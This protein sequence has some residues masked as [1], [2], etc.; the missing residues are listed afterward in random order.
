[1]SVLD[2]RFDASLFDDVGLSFLVNNLWPWVAVLAAAISFWRIRGSAG[3]S[4]SP[5]KPVP[6]APNPAL[7]AHRNPTDEIGV[8]ESPTKPHR[9]PPSHPSAADN[10]ASA[11]PEASTTNA[12][13]GKDGVTKGRFI[14]YYKDEEV[15]REN[16]DDDE[17]DRE[18][19]VCCGGSDGGVGVVRRWRRLGDRERISVMMG[20]GAEEMGWHKCQDLMVFHGSVVRLWQGL[21]FRRSYSW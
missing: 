21:K 8:C 15:Q 4:G 11:S 6:G 2:S 17:G 18:D 1:M 10:S 3:S 13:G 5:T 19:D 20:T 16:D 14:I 9:P 7:A 12:C